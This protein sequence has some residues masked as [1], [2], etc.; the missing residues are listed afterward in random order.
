VAVIV[1]IDLRATREDI[2]LANL[3]LG[4]RHSALLAAA[5]VIAIELMLG[6]IAA[7]ASP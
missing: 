5:S 6:S 1:V 3:G 2:L 4:Q 7:L